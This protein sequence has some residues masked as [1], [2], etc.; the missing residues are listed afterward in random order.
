MKRYFILLIFAT[1]LL[2]GGPFVFGPE[3]NNVVRAQNA[4]STLNELD[5]FA[6]PLA[7]GWNQISIP[8][9]PTESD[10]GIEQI[11]ASIEGS[12]ELLYA[13]DGC[14]D[15]TWLKY[16]PNAPLFVNTLKEIDPTMGLWIKMTQADTLLVSG[17]Q[18][19]QTSIRLCRGWNLIGYPGQN[20][21]SRQILQS[22]EQA[23]P[24]VYRYY[25]HALDSTWQRF[26]SNVPAFANTLSKMKRGE[27]YWVK[28]DED[29]N[30][31]INPHIAQPSNLMGVQIN[32]RLGAAFAAKA[33]QANVS[34]VRYGG[35]VWSDIEAQ[36]G[37]RDWDLLR[38][39]EDDLRA[40]V[41]QGLTPMLI[42]RGTPS[43]AQKVEGAFCGPIKEEALSDFADFMSEVVTR[44]SKPPFNV[45]Y[46]EI[47]N[48]PDIDPSLIDPMEPFGC[49]GD[50]NDEFYGGGYFAK[51]L[52]LVYPAIKAAD[53]DAQV[54]LGGL[55]L[56]CDPTAPPSGKDCHPSHFL[57]GVLRA[58]G[59]EA[60]DIVAYHSYPYWH[61]DVIDSDLS[62]H[63]WQHRGGL[64][65]GKADFIRDVMARYNLNKP[66]MMNEG[67]LLCHP[68]NPTC[69]NETLFDAQASYL[70]RLYAR[71]SASELQ[72]A[73]WYT[74]NGPGWRHGGL[75]DES[76]QPRPA[77][78]ALEFMGQLLAQATYKEQLSDG[79][80]EGYAFTDAEQTVH[81]YWSNDGLRHTV[82]LSAGRKAV[83]DRFGK[84]LA[85]GQTI[86]VGV[87]PIYV[88]MMK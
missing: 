82:S 26:D 84:A 87:E 54:I 25:A 31:L 7:Q 33:N 8:L 28:T 37:E 64:V 3:S 81:I 38:P 9:Q 15:K 47:G 40:F 71:A 13:Y 63:G 1:S 18:A 83:Y 72:A 17:T 75:L 52:K 27:G 35:M 76:Q 56:D 14:Q 88:V 49:W 43:W 6:I 23:N 73:I 46:W 30:F 16:D 66:I 20:Q 29:I 70:P 65:L 45:K 36:Q 58:G 34:W 24:L 77:Y 80:L 60:F 74:L 5:S 39:F 85:F 44:Y 57:E 48:E 79:A 51:M 21:Q 41:A 4:D 55:L 32:N 42:V 78:Q 62:N 59:G 10:I 19:Q 12:Y 68:A 22:I 50:Q 53:P 2:I 67:A 86:S 61:P 69:P 11:L